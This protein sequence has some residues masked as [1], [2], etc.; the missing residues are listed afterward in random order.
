[1]AS[2]IP[3]FEYDIFISYRQKDNKHD[4]WVTEFVDNLKGELE[5]TFKEDISVYFDINPHDGLLETYDVDESLKEKL[6]CLVFI[7]IISRTYCDPKAFAWEHEFKAFVEQASKD[8]FGLKVKLPNGNVANRVLPIRIYDLDTED[9][10]L[11]ESIIGGVLRCVEFIYAE[12]GVNRPLKPD[13]DE[14][15]NLN[16]IK[17][18]NQ[19]N[20]VSNAI[21][22]I[23]L[24]LKTE[25]EEPGKEKIQKKEI[26]K[27]VKKEQIK[28]V[29]EKPAKLLT[30]KLLLGSIILAALVVASILAF[31]K[32]FKRDSL[33]T[34]RTKDKISV[35][36]MPFKNLT[37]DTIFQAIIQNELINSLSSNPE[38]LIVRQLNSITDLLQSESPSQYALITPS[39]ASVV[40]KKLDASVF[41]SGSIIP[42]GAIIRLNAQ[43]ID[44]K[45][46]ETFKSFQI[47]GTADNIIN[48]TD[49]LST[50]ITN[51]LIISVLKKEVSPD[52]QPYKYTNSPEAYRYFISAENAVNKQDWK[53]AVKLYSQAVEID[54]NFHAA[55]IFVSVNYGNLGLYNEAK[56]WC[57]M[58]YKKRDQMSVMD[59]IMTNWIYAKFFETPNEV[60]K[61]SMGSQMLNNQ[62]PVASWQLGNAYNELYQYDKAIAKYEKAL[63]IYNKWEIKP[64]FVGNYTTL[65]FAYHK[66]GQYKKEK[67]L[68]KKAERDFPDDPDLIYRQAVLSLTEGETKAASEYIEKYK[69]I[70]RVNSVSDADITTSLA[71]IYSEAGVLDK[72]EEYYRQAI[73]LEPE[74]PERINNLAY[75]LID[76]DRNINA[77]L[78]LV[79]KALEFSPDNYLF[80]DCKGWGLYKQG[81]YKESKELLEKSDSL[82]PVYNH[83]IYLHI[84]EVKNA[85]A[86]LK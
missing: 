23:I 10:K 31:P 59:K 49:S 35:V 77:G 86:G 85:I 52:I 50:L 32:I 60:I 63:E 37:T 62:L 36:V 45:T 9:V 18:R 75:F 29:H 30:R 84:Q 43:L 3:G 56:K 12:P 64:M 34:L 22:E 6:K 16:K 26:Y 14:K 48:L 73:S 53:S 28:E 17:Y 70:R 13:D 46:V 65:G 4:G 69:S 72:A 81:K 83:R 58:V 19:I 39:V 61:Y 24:G 67:K 11:C 21:K 51:F 5:A 2:L 1:M 78:E 41:I 33:E 82:K 7:P 47:D 79:D 40:A 8:E 57:L 76:K 44:S 66:T 15:I 74:A 68:Y 38:E 71:S 20:K 42:T 25:T 80:L 27:D 55:A 54:S